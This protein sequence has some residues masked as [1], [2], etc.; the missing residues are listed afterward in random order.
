MTHVQ[1]Q[2]RVVTASELQAVDLFRSLP[3]FVASGWSRSLVIVM[4]APPPKKPPPKPHAKPHAK[5]HPKPT[6]PKQTCKTTYVKSCR[7]V[8]DSYHH[9]KICYQK[10]VVKCAAFTEPVTMDVDPHV[11]Q[12]PVAHAW[13]TLLICRC[14]ADARRPR[15]EGRCPAPS[16]GSRISSS[17]LG[18]NL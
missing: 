16:A 10:R 1:S 8:K 3:S 12:D 4:Q 5:P 11:I 18:S 6:K 9:K 17:L 15:E 7:T 2:L 13:S 14:C